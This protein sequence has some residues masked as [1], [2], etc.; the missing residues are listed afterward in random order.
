MVTRWATARP[1]RRVP[2]RSSSALPRSWVCIQAAGNSTI[3]GTVTSSVGGGNR[4]VFGS[5][6]SCSGSA[7][8]RRFIHH[9]DQ[10]SASN[11]CSLTQPDSPVRVTPFSIPAAGNV[12][13]EFA[14]SPS[15]TA[16]TADNKNA[17][18]KDGGW[19]HAHRLRRAQTCQL[20]FSIVTGPTGSLGSISNSFCVWGTPSTDSG[21][22]C[23]NANQN[24]SDSFTYKVNDGRPTP[25]RRPSRSR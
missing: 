3:N 16:P 20:T 18:T 22:P 13:E 25:L 11:A 21:A 24:G 23:R 10:K 17:S 4:R 8:T 15:N 19:D 6:E 7:T 2:H 9:V 1:I 14:P 12:Y 5:S